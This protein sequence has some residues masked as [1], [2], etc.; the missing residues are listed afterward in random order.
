M[1]TLRPAQGRDRRWADQLPKA[2]GSWCDVLVRGRQLTPLIMADRM[3]RGGSRGDKA[4]GRQA[5]LDMQRLVARFA[6][7]DAAAG[8]MPMTEYLRDRLRLGYELAL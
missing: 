3:T 6:R 7:E 4:T 2:A 5:R 1:A 8:R